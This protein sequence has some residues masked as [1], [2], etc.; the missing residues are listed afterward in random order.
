MKKIILSVLIL[1][2]HAI[3]V[4]AQNI[5]VGE[6]VQITGTMNGFSTASTANC[7]YRRISTTAG[8]PA[9]GR[10][11]W[12]KTYNAQVTGG[13]VTN[14]NMPG[15]GSGGF[16]FISGPITN[17]FQN[18]WV[19]TSVM[20]ARI[21]SV[22]ELSAYNTGQDMGLNM[23]APG[24]YTF[25]FNDC[26]YTNIGARYYVGYTA[27]NPVLLNNVTQSVQANNSV[28]LNITTS[29]APS[30]GERVFVRYTSAAGFA[31]TSNT[32]ILEA[33]ATN[34]PTNTNWQLTIP[35]Q[36]MGST[37]RYYAFTSTLTLSKLNQLTESDRTICCLQ[38][39]DN[40][41]S[42]YTVTFTPKY[43]IT[44]SV[45]MANS[46]CFGIDSVTISGAIAPLTNWTGGILMNR[47][48]TTSVYNRTF[49]IDSGATLQYKFRFHR[50][51]AINWE[52]TFATSSGNRE[53]SLI[54]DSI[55]STFCFG[56]TAACAAVP[57]PSTITFAV[58]LTG[59]SP[60]PQGRIYV[61]GNFTTASWISGAI[62][63]TP[64]PGLANH[65]QAVVNNVCPATFE[66]RFVNGDSSIVANQESFPNPAQRTCTVSNGFGGFNRAYTRV[67]TNPVLLG[68]VFNAC[69]TA[70]PVE[71]L[72]ISANRKGYGAIIHWST[73]SETNNRGFFVQKSI[74]GVDFEDIGF[75][76]GSGESKTQRNYS[77][78]NKDANQIGY[79]RIKQ[80]DFN[81]T[82]A[83]SKIVTLEALTSDLNL[84]VYPIPFKDNVTIHFS[85][86]IDGD[87]SW[88]L[89]NTSGMLLQ[90]GEQ[91]KTNSFELSGLDNYQSGVYYLKVTCNNI[92]KTVKL[93]K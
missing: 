90:E 5:F 29:A 54:K 59:Q 88:S 12:I 24:R 28:V 39:N 42:N 19:F 14:I 4:I 58:N 70:L 81:E 56:T 71:F 80:V 36:P 7:T 65:F 10:G 21:D 23:S 84:G 74:N 9:D 27:N 31:S 89:Y 20:Q 11:Q 87:I 43:N 44:F 78:Y 8:A 91:T 34:S 2:I 16:L 33:T 49:L 86:E 55:L 26:G 25:V 72:S 63:M 37:I 85:E 75:V 47:V 53:L 77:F 45:N 52:G 64:I 38:V 15:G 93:I 46:N 79:Y 68:F 50:N 61:V 60:D 51:G 18:K 92:A 32:T 35:A 22:N 48:G 3:P 67:N 13:D 73:A 62:R 83:Y 6:P 30:P 76:E 1:T 66:Y 57:A 17:R 69:N 41:G 40:S 82:Y